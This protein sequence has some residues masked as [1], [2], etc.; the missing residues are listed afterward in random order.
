MISEERLKEAARRCEEHMLNYLPDPSECEATFSP[1]F[2][3][4]MKRLFFKINHP[5]IFRISRI[6]SPLLLTLLSLFVMCLFSMQP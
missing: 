2:E 4:K 5:L 6:I 1:R 3:G